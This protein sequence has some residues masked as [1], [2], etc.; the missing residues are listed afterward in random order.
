VCPTLKVWLQM[1]TAFELLRQ[2]E[3]DLLRLRKE[4]D[5]LKIA[6]ALLRDDADQPAYKEEET[7][8]HVQHT[9]TEGCGSSNC[10][11]SLPSDRISH[12]QL[13]LLPNPVAGNF[14][15]LPW[16]HEK[17]LAVLASVRGPARRWWLW[18]A[19]GMLIVVVWGGYLLE[20]RTRH[21]AQATGS[22]GVTATASPQPSASNPETTPART[23]VAIQHTGSPA[24]RPTPNQSNPGK[25]D[26]PD[27]DAV[28]RAVSLVAP[29]PMAGQSASEDG[30]QELILGRRYL[31]GQGVPEDHATAAQWL[32]KSV[33][34]QNADATLLLSDLYARGDGVPKSCD[35]ARILLTIAG[36]RG[37]PEAIFKLEVIENDSCR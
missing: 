9:G 18:T 14:N 2:K 37:S 30:S 3:L 19:R 17:K 25:A 20:H 28:Q 1:K 8:Q 16:L 36:K 26:S 5:A 22:A 31:L 33:A 12:D 6:S 32:W 15:V 35:Q 23:Q 4:T 7:A 11:F 13:F 34:K 27:E 24:Q 21:Q 10:G 29:V